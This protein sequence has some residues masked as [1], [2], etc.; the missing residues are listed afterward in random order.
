MLLN[1]LTQAQKTSI[2]RKFLATSQNGFE[3]N[4]NSPTRREKKRFKKSRIKK[5]TFVNK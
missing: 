2:S 5:N 4:F 3:N 1:F